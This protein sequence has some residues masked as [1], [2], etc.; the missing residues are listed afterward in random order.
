MAPR[1]FAIFSLLLTLLWVG[2]CS[3]REVDF[4]SKKFPIK[5]VIKIPKNA[6]SQS[7]YIVGGK[8]YIPFQQ[9]VLGWREEGIA[10]WYG[11]DFHSRMTASGEKYNMFSYTA[12]HKTLPLGTIIRVTNLKNRKSIVVKINDRG[13]FVA[14]RIIDLSYSAAKVLGLDRA[15]TGKVELQVIGYLPPKQVSPI[16]SPVGVTTTG[17]AGLSS[18]ERLYARLEQKSLWEQLKR[19]LEQGFKELIHFF[20]KLNPF[21]R[22][23]E[24]DL[25]LSPDRAPHK[26]EKNSSSKQAP[27]KTGKGGQKGEKRG[28]LQR[29]DG[30]GLK[31]RVAAYRYRK[32][33]ERLVARLRKRRYNSYLIKRG[34]Y[35]LVIVEFRNWQELERF[36]R[37]E[38]LKG[39]PIE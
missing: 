20:K 37:R 29:G 16:L 17:F 30:K 12:A 26:R 13:P 18:L 28:I 14:N 23:P 7:P 15:G 5:A 24:G 36:R 2:G 11:P 34:K 6:P 9:L 1:L 35:Y 27:S 39:V 25:S 3:H 31:Y 8:V 4:T 33:G 19:K 32:N 22:S 21:N 10:S 38:H